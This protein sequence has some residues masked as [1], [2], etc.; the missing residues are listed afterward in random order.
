MREIFEEH[1]RGLYV[2]DDQSALYVK[3]SDWQGHLRFTLDA[4][5]CSESWFADITGVENL[6][7]E[8]VT[9]IELLEMP[10]VDDSRSR[11]ESD[12]AYGYR[13]KTRKGYTDIVFRN[14]SNGY[15][16]G[17]MNAAEVVKILPGD[18]YEITKDWRAEDCPAKAS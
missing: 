9:G 14:S 11:Q 2:N 18:L 3:R 8:T 7:G 16:G 12:V 10:D 6:I 4:D 15:Y 17:S 1:V 5:C 13:L